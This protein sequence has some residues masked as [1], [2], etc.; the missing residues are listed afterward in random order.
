MFESCFV[1]HYQPGVGRS[2][3]IGEL[4]YETVEIAVTS[5]AFSL[6][7]RHQIKALGLLDNLVQSGFHVAGFGHSCWKIQEILSHIFSQIPYGLRRL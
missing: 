4:F 5:R 6:S 3:I 2:Q 7:H 1:V